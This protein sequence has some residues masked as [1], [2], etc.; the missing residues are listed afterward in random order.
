LR[1]ISA[2]Q[3]L[4]IGSKDVNL[5]KVKLRFRERRRSPKALAKLVPEPGTS[6]AASSC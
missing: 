2:P 1:A 5:R 6:S 4:A 3:W